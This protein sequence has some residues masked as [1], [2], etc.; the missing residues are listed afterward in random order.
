[1]SVPASVA[2]HGKIWLDEAD[3][4]T[5]L[6]GRKAEYSGAADLEES[7][8]VLWRTFGNTLVNRG[9]LWWF[10]IAGGKSFSHEK[11]WNDFGNMRREMLYTAENQT[12]IDRTRSIAVIMDTESI[13]FRRFSYRDQVSGNLL[14]Y[15]R[16]VFAKSGVHI[17]SYIT[18]DLE[19][20]P[21]DYPI[22]IFVNSFYADSAKREV[23]ARRFKKDNKVLVWTYGAGYFKNNTPKDRLSVS[24]ANMTDLTGIKMDWVLKLCNFETAPAAG[25][26]IAV[27]AQKFPHKL[28]PGLVV[29]DPQAQILA[30]F[31]NDP[32]LAG[33]GAIA[34][35][36]MPNWRSIYLGIPE[37]NVETVRAIAQ[38]G[39]AHV[40]TDAKNV[41]VRPG[42]G[43]IIIHSGHADSVNITLPQTAKRVVDVESGKVICNNSKNFTVKIGKN[44]TL[45][46]RIE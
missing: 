45:L 30:K 18:D 11:I 10:P 14:T 7:R 17:D 22:Y 37:F 33:K 24:P 2:M 25:S 44:R 20:I 5:S 40:Y 6:N 19:L 3:I 23:I 9:S 31:V 28:N 15:S 13:H 32:A 43:H 39:G 46:L 21:D 38:Y 35:K 4:R 16:D 27:P 41:V 34:V 42:N 26:K 12:P 29:T 8:A 1:M 36:Q